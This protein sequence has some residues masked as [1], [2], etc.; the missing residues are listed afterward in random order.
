MLKVEKT[1]GLNVLKNYDWFLVFL[2]FALNAYGLIV[3]TSVSRQLGTPGNIIKQAIGIA[4]GSIAMV[5]LS[6]IDYKDLKILGF[7]AYGFTTLL[8][9]LVM[10]F[11]KGAEETGT[12]G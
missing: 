9:V 2:I 10:I 11:G 1:Q 5:I 6:L 8:L 3:I 12:Q 4:A 7:A